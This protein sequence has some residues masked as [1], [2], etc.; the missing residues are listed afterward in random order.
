MQ[1]LEENDPEL[2]GRTEEAS[3][4]WRRNQ[5]KRNMGGYFVINHGHTRFIFKSLK[6]F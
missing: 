6:S 2:G 5:K 4:E 1:V 3:E